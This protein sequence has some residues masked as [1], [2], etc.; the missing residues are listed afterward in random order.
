M[1]ATEPPRRV[2]YSVRVNGVL[3]KAVSMQI[4][5]DCILGDVLDRVHEKKLADAIR[6][7]VSAADLRVFLPGT[8]EFD[9]AHKSKLS[10]VVP[11]TTEEKPVIID[12]PPPA[13]RSTRSVPA[14]IL[15]PRDLATATV[16]MGEHQPASVAASW[17][18]RRARL[19]GH[20]NGLR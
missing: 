13:A 20:R 5:R 8:T 18:R 14:L 6:Q 7:R 19:H 11:E 9:E 2:W 4:D 16:T 15:A 17:P 3:S 12:V 10:V 1:A